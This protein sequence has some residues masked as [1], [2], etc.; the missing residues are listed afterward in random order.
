MVG[1]LPDKGAGF[2]SS[3]SNVFI[4]LSTY[5]QRLGR[6]NASG[7]PTVQAVYVSAADADDLNGL[8]AD[9]NLL[10]AAQH[11]T[12][13]PDDYD[14]RVQNQADTARLA[15]LRH[16]HPDAVP[17]RHRGPSACWSAASAS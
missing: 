2:G 4:P 14:F 3:N 17:R 12:P 11:D 8:V 10:L 7:E 13:S 5:L 9:L 16:H 6:Q 1:V 15:Q